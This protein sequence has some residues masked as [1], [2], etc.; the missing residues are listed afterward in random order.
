MALI[1]AFDFLPA[2][3]SLQ[4]ARSRAPGRPGLFIDQDGAL[5]EPMPHGLDPLLLRLRPGAGE[6]LARLQAAGLALVIVTN[7]SGL[8]SGRITRA[9]FARLQQLLLQ[10]LQQEFGVRVDGVE[11]CPHSPDSQGRPACLCRLPAPGMLT[12]A[13]HRHGMDLKRSWMVGGTLD[14]VEAGHRAG[15]RGLLLDSGSETAWRRSPLREPDAR[16]VDWAGVAAHVEKMN[17][18]PEAAPQPQWAPPGLHGLPAA[19]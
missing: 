19:G 15:A 8:A 2:M 10:R 13:G 9:E 16:F 4:P 6:A 1:S 5:I 17:A 11:V 14:D 3:R 18:C 12:R 7:Q